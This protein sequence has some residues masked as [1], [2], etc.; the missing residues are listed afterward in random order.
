MD[1]SNFYHRSDSRLCFSLDESHVLIRLSV[2]KKEMVD[3][4]SIIYGDPIPFIK[5]HK[6]KEMTIKHEDE[7][8]YYY[9]T[10]VEA[11]PMRLMYIFHIRYQKEDYFFCESGLYKEFQYHLSFL[12]AFQFVGEN[13]NDFVLDNPVWKGRVI[14]Q[15]FVD[16]FASRSSP[17]EKPYVNEKW[18]SLNLKGWPPRFLGGDIYGI[19]DKLDYLSWLGVEGI[20]LTPIYP[21]D[22]NHKYDIKDYFDVDEMFGGKEAFKELINKAHALDIKIMLDLVFNHTSS[23]HP[24]FMDVINNGKKSKYYDW[25]F[26]D[27]DYPK[28]RPLNY[29]CFSYHSG[30]PKLNTNNKEVQDY[31]IEVGKYWIKE[32]DVDGY[33]L[34]VSEGV[35]HDFWIR[36]KIALLDIKPDIFLIGENWRNAESYL[37]NDQ[38]DGVMNYPFL[39]A[40]SNYVLN[41]FTAKEMYYNLENLLMRHKDG[42]NRK[43]MNL[44]ATHDIQRVMNLV[45]F[46]KDLSLICYALLIFYIGN[47]LI[48]YGE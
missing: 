10:I 2:S 47:P 5:D 3:S 38:L 24:M 37:G 30:M 14:Y 32:F 8:L 26:I 36:F 6:E 13:K 46:D 22:S 35:S 12:S 44:V 48:Y 42:H 40:V 9:E 34:D 16:R 7:A 17:S 1:A 45:K 15:I 31:L 33:R 20:Y 23:R 4:I 21:S 11:L 29:R 19:I 39:G 43:M 18:N 28:A 25:Y 41:Q 27:G